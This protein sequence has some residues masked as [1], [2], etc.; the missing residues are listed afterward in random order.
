[1]LFLASYARPKSGI[2]AGAIVHVQSRDA[3]R[4]DCR[5][6][7]VRLARRYGCGDETHPAHPIRNSRYQQA[8]RVRFKGLEPRA[9][10]FGYV[11]VD[12]RECLKITFRMAGGDTAGMS[13]DRACA[14]ACAADQL[15]RLAE[16]GE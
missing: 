8:G 4:L 3:S 13:S 10:L 7:G 5:P 1:M 14:R 12:L 16:R 11:A 6:D 2:A 15:R 9:D